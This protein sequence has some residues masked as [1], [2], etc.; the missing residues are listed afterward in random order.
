M[1]ILTQRYNGKQKT[2]APDIKTNDRV[3][4][5]VCPWDT[6]RRI[7]TLPLSTAVGPPRRSVPANVETVDTGEMADIS[8]EKRD[9]SLQRGGGDPQIVV[10]DSI[11][12]S[13]HRAR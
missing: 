3:V 13:A 8:C 10:A 5:Y 4:T 12:F 11:S 9:S 1:Q 6:A 7:R 2:S